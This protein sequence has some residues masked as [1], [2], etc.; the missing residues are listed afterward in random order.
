MHISRLTAKMFLFGF[1][2]LAAILL[3]VSFAGA[4]L[5]RESRGERVAHF[6]SPP[7]KVWGAL[8]EVES[9][10]NWRPDVSAVQIRPSVDGRLSWR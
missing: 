9:Y 7:E 2:A 5:P 3:G 1:A 6:K 10:P 4:L 8:I